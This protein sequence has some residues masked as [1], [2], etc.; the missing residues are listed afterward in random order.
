MA[1]ISITLIAAMYAHFGTRFN[2]ASAAFH[3]CGVWAAGAGKASAGESVMSVATS[4]GINLDFLADLATLKLR[5]SVLSDVP[6]KTKTLP[7]IARIG[8]NQTS[9]QVQA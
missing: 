4:V 9:G 2:A 1:M 8:A 7:R 5:K 3:F 6:V